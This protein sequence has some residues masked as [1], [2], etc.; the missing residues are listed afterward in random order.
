MTPA[1][2]RIFLAA[3]GCLFAFAFAAQATSVLPMYLDE[4]ADNA[5]V[6]FQ[7]KCVGNRTELDHARNTVVTYTTFE[8]RDVVKGNVGAVHEIKQIGGV[9]PSEGLDQRVRGVPT[10]AE[11]EEYVVFL[12]GVSSHGFSSPLGLAQGRFAVREEGASKR[13]GNGRDFRDIAA[14]MSE[15]LP[16]RA[17][18]RV[19]ESPAPVLDMD[20][21]DFKQAVRH[22]IGAPR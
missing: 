14:R 16:A 15:H 5:A 6:V 11:G 8:V 20:L 4:L 1:F 17:R 13:V 2:A 22:R 21:E 19:A 7:A 3:I 9:L 18:A 12:A 10:F